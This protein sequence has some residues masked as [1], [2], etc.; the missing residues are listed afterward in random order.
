M[1][2]FADPYSS[3]FSHILCSLKFTPIQR[4][5]CFLVSNFVK[6]LHNFTISWYNF[7]LRICN[8]KYIKY[9]YTLWIKYIYT[10]PLPLLALFKHSNLLMYFCF[11]SLAAILFPNSVFQVSNKRYRWFYNIVTLRC[12]APLEGGL[13]I[14]GCAY[15]KASKWATHTKF[16]NFVIFSFQITMNN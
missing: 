6:K 5:L 13:L 12:D 3:V 9:I 15:F 16:Q 2:V 10:S 4:Y 14:E 8:S 7:L 11:I 1:Q